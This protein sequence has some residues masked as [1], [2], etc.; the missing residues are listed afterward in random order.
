VSRREPL[1]TRRLF[2]IPADHF[3]CRRCEAW[4]NPAFYE[5][6]HPRRDKKHPRHEPETLIGVLGLT[7]YYPPDSPMRLVE[8]TGP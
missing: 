2:N 3:W 5:R 4:L 8:Q 6:Q 1:R 7:A